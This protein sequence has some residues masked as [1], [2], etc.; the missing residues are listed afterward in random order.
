MKNRSSAHWICTLIAPLLMGAQ[1]ATYAADSV[2]VFNEAHYHPAGDQT[3]IE[4][5]E[6]YN[7]LAVDVDL[8]NW[9]I[10]GDIDFDFPEGT[11][12]GARG[13]LVIAKDPDDLEDAT[14]YGG[15]LGPWNRDLSNSG[16]PIYLYNNNRS[17]R[18]KAGGTGSVGEVT[19]DLEAR[20]IMD[21]LY[22]KDTAP[23]PMGPDGSGF[24]LA[25]R[26]PNTGTAH[27]ENWRVS[28][29]LNGTPGSANIFS[30]LPAIAFNEIEGTNAASFQLELINH[31]PSSISLSGWVIASSNPLHSDYTF[32]ATT[33]TSGDFL[34]LDAATLGFTPEDNNRL[35]LYTADKENLVDTARADNLLIARNPEGTGAWAHPAQPTFGAANIFSISDSIVINEIFYHA[36]PQ[37]AVDGEPPSFTDLQVLNYDAIWR[38]NLSAGTPGLAANWAAEAHPVDNI[39]WAEGPGL[40]G[41]ENTTLGEPLQTTITKTNQQ[42][43]YY[44]E[45]DFSYTD[46]EPITAMV[47]RHYIDDGA[48]FYLNGTEIGRFNMAEGNVVAANL[49]SVGV[50]NASLNSFTVNNPMLLQGTNRLSVEVHQYTTGSSDIVCGAQVTLRQSDGTG[51]PGTPFVERDEE[52]IELYNR[53]EAAV[54]LTGWEINGG[55]DYK[56]PEGTSLP[57]GD[58]LVIAKDAAALGVKHPGATILGDYSNR[59]GDGGDQLRIEDAAGNIVDEVTYYDSGKWHAAADGGGSSLE[60]RD[61]DADN[62]L[63]GAW[64]PSDESLRSEWQTYTYEGVAE[65]DGIGYDVYHEF[66]VGML[67]AGEFLLDDVSVVEEGS[68]EFIQ[69][70]D[71]ESDVVG[72]TAE[73]WRAIGTHGSHGKTVV[74]T[75]PSDPGNQCLHVVS[76]GP[77]ENKHNKLE[78]TYAN[79]EEVVVGNT[80]RISFR[81]KWISGMNLVN[82][83]LHFNF[84][85]KTSALEVPEVWGTPGTVNTVAEPNIGPDLENLSHSPVM[86]DVNQAVTVSIQAS[87]ADGVEQLTLFYSIDDGNF[88]STT[89]AGGAN[90]T[91]SGIIPGQAAGTSIRFYVQGEDALGATGSFPA[92]GSQ[93]GAFCKVQ[94][95]L[96]DSS[97]LRHNF[98]IIMSEA[99]R[100]FL[101]LD[102]NRMSNDRFPVTVI[103]DETTVYYDVGLRL[104]AS[105]HGRYNGYGYN[106]QFQPD[107]LF[108]GVHHSISIESGSSR[109]LFAKVL[110]NRAGGGYWSFYDDV[111]YVVEPNGTR[112]VRLLSMARHTKTFWDGLFPEAEQGGT[113]FNLELHYAPNGTTG[114]PEDLKIGNPYNHTNGAYDLLDRGTG[115]EPYRWGFQIRSARDRDDYSQ[116]IALNQAMELSGTD[117]K[118]AL[119]PLIDVDQWMRTFA[120]MSLNGTDDVY[121]RI[122]EHNFR[123][124]VRPT[125]Q[126]IIVLQWDLDRTFRYG[127]NVS[128]IPTDNNVVKLFSIPEY[129]RVFD[130]H[131]NDL[132]LSTFN[133]TYA[134]PWASHLGTVSGWNVN[135]LL[136]AIDNRATPAQA[137]LPSI[138]AFEITTN[139]GN[140]F[141]EEDSTIDLS[142]IGWV[143][144]FSIVVNG[145]ETPVSWTGSKDWKITVPIGMGANL[146]TLTAL[147]NRGTMVGSDTITVTNT[148]PIDLARA[149]NIM[150]SELQYHPLDPTA[151]E[152][153]AGFTDADDFEFVELTSTAH[154]DI[155]LTNIRFS[156]GIDFIYPAGTMLAPGERIVAVANQAAFLFR[157]GTN[158][159]TIAG[160]YSGKFNNAGERVRLDAAD[161]TVIIDF[162]YSDDFPW[163]ESTDGDG[164]SLIFSGSDPSQPF[165]WRPSTTAGG[166][167]GTTDVIPYSGGDLNAYAL[168]AKPTIEFVADAFILNV[169]LNLAADEAVLQY[170]FSTNLFNWTPSTNLVSRQNHGDGTSSISIQSPY[171]ISTQPKQ[172]G[173]ATIHLR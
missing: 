87:D 53:R 20:R 155:D 135:A 36:Y 159:A 30:A 156:N 29:Q 104:K 137:S 142:G 22:Y 18:S 126:K 74:V 105:A 118:E 166:N 76:T 112:G 111:S 110:M 70:G 26:D 40:L 14:G 68:I 45:T 91:Y 47:I 115:K 57:A 56:M 79:S 59:L 81:A 33:L 72:A 65:E 48:I 62:A 136:S 133:S 121:S 160:E 32:P 1:F 28:T 21:E 73:K 37:R 128:I 77:T 92:A 124:Y 167:P 154:A 13:Y 93:G 149:G 134:T 130:G 99:D 140:D 85:Q 4:Y 54:D 129:R 141:S 106:I 168:A 15:A 10:D 132:V 122:W 41:F 90:G 157:Y 171:P 123:F 61:P 114:G 109:E 69:N 169:H 146:L 63:A 38:Y 23:W 49:A 46:E 145:V 8:S 84:L 117:L 96:A 88:Q 16:D 3:A 9:R 86:P 12:I 127:S 64:A 17:F 131:L 34:V 151:A 100:T 55:I 116:L 158:T 39:D 89:M 148:S 25:K 164:Y 5:L 27:P 119:D 44:F 2:V 97:G 31:G 42:I 24:S 125:D 35:F 43:T 163:P 153:T 78:T 139:S 71:F 107:Q 103:E 150:L 83:R 95:G 138:S 80:Y 172:Y 161:G 144:V 51:T 165:D 58:Y 120:M 113:L 66:I 82:T 11:V 101:F 108:R 143:D 19:A 98:R 67:D 94:D 6:L 102:T 162:E 60:L 75:D 152:L 170:S 50:G 147:D 7:Q 52:W 173:N